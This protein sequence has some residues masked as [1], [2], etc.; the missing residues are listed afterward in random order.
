VEK[1]DPEKIISASEYLPLRAIVVIDRIKISKLLAS[2]IK[3]S[4][5]EHVLARTLGIS[6]SKVNDLRHGRIPIKLGDL[7]KL[8]NHLGI[9]PTNLSIQGFSTKKGNRI[10]IQWEQKLTSELA[11]LLGI[12]LGDKNE[13]PYSVGIG[14]S[15][16]E[17][18]QAFIEEITSSLRISCAEIHC[19]AS[20]PNLS[21]NKSTYRTEFAKIFQLPKN[22]IHLQ[23]PHASQRHKK[24]HFTMKLF[25]SIASEMFNRLDQRLEEIL[26]PSSD[27]AKYAFVRGVIDSDGRVRPWGSVE[28][29]MRTKNRNKIMI[30]RS[31]L[32]LLEMD[33]S[34]IHHRKHSDMVSL[35][36][37]ATTKNIHIL[38]KH[39]GSTLP[40]K[41]K[42]IEKRLFALR[43]GARVSRQ[44][45]VSRESADPKV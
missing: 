13:G 6:R 22:R 1:G 33:I 34:K 44:C 24:T 26:S 11:W 4:G 30:I 9:K 5:T 38:G 16:V 28:I 7:V 31:I 37:Y 36:I 39:I 35:T 14:T 12:R 40:R 32:S 23:S 18:A 42:R 8:C 19:Y 29:A 41:K 3:R 21:K 15:D 27:D 20:I 25:N 2:A 17:I 45:V 43:K 10:N